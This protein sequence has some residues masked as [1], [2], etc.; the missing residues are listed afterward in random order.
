MS[1]AKFLF[2]FS[3]IFVFLFPIFVC[4]SFAS[5]GEDLAVSAID[6][7]EEAVVSAYDAVLKAEQAGADVSGL[8]VRLN[9]AGEVLAEAQVAFRLG[10]FDEAVRLADLCIEVVEGVSGEADELRLGA[11]GPKVTGLLVAVFGSLVGVF[12]VVLGSFWAWSVFKRRYYR[13]V[14]KMKPEV[15]KGES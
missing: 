10:E 9:D 12:V 14:W 15:A 8:L 5:V 7:A 13:R 4:D 11:H 6:R 3:V 1:A 2:V